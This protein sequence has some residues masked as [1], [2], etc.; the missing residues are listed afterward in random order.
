MSRSG[1]IRNPYHLAK[2]QNVEFLT[3]VLMLYTRAYRLYLSAESGPADNKDGS[4]ESHDEQHRFHTFG[5]VYTRVPG[6]VSLDYW[7]PRVDPN[8]YTPLG[9]ELIPPKLVTLRDLV[10]CNVGSI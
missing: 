1:R 8:R 5:Y 4:L 10:A 9:L 6:S 3:A 7:F 2:G